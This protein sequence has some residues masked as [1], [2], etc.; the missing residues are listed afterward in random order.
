MAFYDIQPT[1]MTIPGE[2][3][4]TLTQIFMQINYQVGM[5]EMTVPYN[6]C[7]AETKSW[8][9]APVVIDQAQ[10]DQ[11]GT[12]DMYIVNLVATAAGVTLV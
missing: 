12:D 9:S 6:L 2:G 1:T 11:W 10:L 4:I 8:Y 3:T 5:E 7:D